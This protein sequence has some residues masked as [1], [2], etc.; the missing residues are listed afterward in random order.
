LLVAFA[1]FFLG[2]VFALIAWA[3]GTLL[4]LELERV[5]PPDVLGLVAAGLIFY[6]LYCTLVGIGL[7]LTGDLQARSSTRPFQSRAHA[8]AAYV[9]PMAVDV[10]GVSPWRLARR[11][12][13]NPFVVFFVGAL[14]PLA[15]LALL[16]L[17]GT[18][19]ALRNV[20]GWLARRLSEEGR[21]AAYMV[22]AGVICFVS[23]NLLQ[24]ASTF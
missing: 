1:L 5:G 12:V 21:L 9:F 10:R 8:V 11:L 4:R 6:A 22:S 3:G 24:L 18:L 13:I 7:L 2:Y 17:K 20:A 14:A 15:A 19:M 16:V 23:G